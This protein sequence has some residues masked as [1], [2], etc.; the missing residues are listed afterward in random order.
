V[1]ALSGDTADNPSAAVA[2]DKDY[3]HLVGLSS[4]LPGLGQRTRVV[5]TAA[6]DLTQV[7]TFSGTAAS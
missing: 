6:I 3:T 2:W 5:G 7:V 4:D 1:I